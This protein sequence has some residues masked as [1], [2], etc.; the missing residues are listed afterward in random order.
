MAR[1]PGYDDQKWQDNRTGRHNDWLTTNTQFLL[2]RVA[3]P[4][5]RTP[6][7]EGPLYPRRSPYVGVFASRYPVYTTGGFGGKGPGDGDSEASFAGNE[8]KKKTSSRFRLCITLVIFF[9]LVAV[10]LA[11][12]AIYLAVRNNDTEESYTGT[13][14]A[15][16]RMAKQK[17]TDKLDDVTST[18]YSDKQKEFCS[19]VGTVTEIYHGWVSQ[20]NGTYCSYS[21]L[22][23]A[24][25]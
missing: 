24:T 1:R 15:T 23:T 11:I 6:V 12:V 22:G 10:A 9:V 17:F 14:E 8:D 18:E 7:A 2:P 13:Y 4:A 20:L 3:Y 16:V 21:C 19:K 25:L 5:H